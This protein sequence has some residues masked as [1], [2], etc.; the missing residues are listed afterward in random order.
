MQATLEILFA[1]EFIS[2]IIQLLS[3]ILIYDYQ[4]YICL[5]AEVMLWGRRSLQQNVLF[6]HKKAMTAHDTQK[7][8]FSKSHP[9]CISFFENNPKTFCEFYFEKVF[10]YSKL[11]WKAPYEFS[12]III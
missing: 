6:L 1:F 9:I 5:H 11:D 8:M 3:G 4:I 10:G 2:E 12:E 7:E